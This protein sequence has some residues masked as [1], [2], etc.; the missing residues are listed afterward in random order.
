MYLVILQIAKIFCIGLTL[1]VYTPIHPT[2]PFF[3]FFVWSFCDPPMKVPVGEIL[4]L[5]SCIMQFIC[6][7]IYV[8]N[9]FVCLFFLVGGGG[10]EWVGVGLK[11]V[12]MVL[13]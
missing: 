8:V 12:H 1:V 9:P 7:C 6:L 4:T 5:L 10:V 3:T 11:S 2:T 13:C